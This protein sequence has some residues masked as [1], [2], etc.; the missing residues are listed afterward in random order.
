MIIVLGKCQNTKSF[1][2]IFVK[3]SVLPSAALIL[4]FLARFCE[5][6]LCRFEFE[7]FISDAIKDSFQSQQVILKNFGGITDV[8]CVA[9]DCVDCSLFNRCNG[10]MFFIETW[11]LQCRIRKALYP[12]RIKYS[13]LVSDLWRSCFLICF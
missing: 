2:I 6:T 4:P 1:D 3:Q 12:L 7:T 10:L 8:I 11:Q 9:Q 5:A 13:S